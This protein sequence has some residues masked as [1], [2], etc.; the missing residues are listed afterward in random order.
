MDKFNVTFKDPE[1]HAHR[2]SVFAKNLDI[3]K[4]L[5]EKKEGGEGVVF[6]VTQLSHLTPEEFKNQ[7]LVSDALSAIVPESQRKHKTSF[8][9]TRPLPIHG[10]RQK[11]QALPTAFDWRTYSAVTSV[12]NQGSCGCCWAFAAVGAVESQYAL[13]NGGLLNLAEQEVLNCAQSN[14]CSGG[15]PHAA[16]DLIISNGVHY[17]S[18]APYAQ[19][20]NTCNA[21]SGTKIT[22]DY[23]EEMWGWSEEDM[24]QYLYD[25]GPF[26]VSIGMTTATQSYT[27][28]IYN[29]SSCVPINHAMLVIG[30]GNENGVDYWLVKNQWGTGWGYSGYMKIKRNVNVCSFAQQNVAPYNGYVM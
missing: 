2:L 28:G 4:E 30:W 14:G 22:S 13:W 16:L 11:R 6:G 20:K 23:K 21:L 9:R 27:S 29:P 26:A 3:I 15:T 1:E 17:E 24:R 7:I 18:A 5:N 19:V 8:N 10:R 12:K 25:Y